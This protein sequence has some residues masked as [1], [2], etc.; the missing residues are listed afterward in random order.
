[1]WSM[2]SS[3]RDYEESRR[4][5]KSL[6][7]RRNNNHLKITISKTDEFVG[8][9]A[10]NMD[11]PAEKLHILKHQHR[12]SIQ[13]WFSIWKNMK[14]G[15][16]LL[17]FPELWLWVMAR[18]VWLTFDLLDKKV[19]LISSVRHL[20]EMLLESAHESLSDVLWNPS[21]LWPST[22]KFQS[23][24]NLFCQIWRRHE[25]R[26]GLTYNPKTQSLWPQ[27]IAVSQ[28]GVNV[29]FPLSRE[30]RATR[31]SRRGIKK[32]GEP[33]F[34]PHTQTHT[35]THTHSRKESEV[36]QRRTESHRSS[37]ETEKKKTLTLLTLYS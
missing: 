4:P 7:T 23:E 25:N 31:R 33:L 19:V 27:L 13:D 24:W 37:V 20:C 12:G 6:V 22:T 35:H 34:L 17:L 18:K 8:Y 5:M 21:D 30:Q 2:L 29:C 11:F 9:N 32:E 14:Y 10:S 16:S 15:H 3:L 26:N 1:M 28:D 36:C